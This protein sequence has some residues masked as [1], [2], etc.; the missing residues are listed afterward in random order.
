[1]NTST[2]SAATENAKQSCDAFLS[3]LAGL[4]TTWAAYGLKIGKMALLHSADALGKTAHT[5]ETLAAEL[6]KKAAPKQAGD[7]VVDADA[8]RG[9]EAAP[10]PPVA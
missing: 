7:V 1:M 10:P 9:N 4:G 8:P 3:T 2:V 6:E 5:L